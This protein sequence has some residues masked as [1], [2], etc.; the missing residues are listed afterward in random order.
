[1]KIDDC[2]IGHGSL[3]ND[4]KLVVRSI[5]VYN[6]AGARIG[7]V[8]RKSYSCCLLTRLVAARRSIIQRFLVAVDGPQ[9]G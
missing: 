8:W 5:Y 9:K 7:R 3:G 1:M 4:R 2:S 6:N